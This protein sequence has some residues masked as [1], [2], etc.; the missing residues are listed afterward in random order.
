VAKEVAGVI[1]DREI[2][3]GSGDASGSVPLDAETVPEV[4]NMEEILFQ[5]KTASTI[6]TVIAAI[7][8]VLCP[9]M[10]CPRSDR[11][12]K[13]MPEHGPDSYQNDR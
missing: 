9:L 2:F 1:G 4:V 10:L 11:A 5:N 3:P 7:P 8:R 6:K 13:K 12:W